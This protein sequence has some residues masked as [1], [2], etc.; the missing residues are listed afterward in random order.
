MEGE[1]EGRR[2][3][4]EGR[5]KNRSL[6][7]FVYRSASPMKIISSLSV[8]PLKLAYCPTNYPTHISVFVNLQN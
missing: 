8:Y 6:E 2:K 4:E 1:R 7:F 5:G 3:E